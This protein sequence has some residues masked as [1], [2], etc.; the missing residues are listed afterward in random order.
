[1]R[2]EDMLTPE[3]LREYN[4]WRVGCF[5]DSPSDLDIRDAYDALLE[6]GL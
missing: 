1:M 6:E 3:D 5:N 4:E 2:L